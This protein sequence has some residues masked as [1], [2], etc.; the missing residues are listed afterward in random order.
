MN[1]YAMVLKYLKK[2]AGLTKKADPRFK[3]VHDPRYVAGVFDPAIHNDTSRANSVHF[4]SPEG[5]SLLAY[6]DT[7]SASKLNYIYDMLRYFQNNDPKAYQMH[8]ARLLPMINATTK[9]VKQHTKDLS[10]D[11]I[12]MW[13]SFRSNPYQAKIKGKNG[14][15]VLD[16]PT[17]G[18]GTTVIDG[19]TVTMDTAP[20]T[21]ERATQLLQDWITQ[22]TLPD[23]RAAYGSLLENMTHGQRAALTSLGYNSP[24][25]MNPT[26]SIVQRIR[27]GEDVGTVIAEEFPHWNKVRDENKKKVVSPGLTNRR[28]KEISLAQ[29]GTL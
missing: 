16:K 18:Y 14:Q 17:I 11:A 13:E 3:G 6:R 21:K 9:N 10:T 1:K 22:K 2:R 23:L 29:T 20:I 12:K 4:D 15:I 5:K 27:N 19:K 26:K 25:S 24:K 8:K 28:N 7:G